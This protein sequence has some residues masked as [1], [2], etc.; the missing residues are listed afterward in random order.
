M[1]IWAGGLR[2]LALASCASIQQQSIVSTPVAQS[3]LRASEMWF[4]ALKAA[5]ACQMLSAA[6]TYS[7]VLARR[8]LRTLRL[9]VGAGV[10]GIAARAAAVVGTDLRATHLEGGR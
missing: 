7:A 8:V 9:W 3:L 2:S 10:A 5:K 6:P 4:S 1:N